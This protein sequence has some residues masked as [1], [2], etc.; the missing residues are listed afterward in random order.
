[1][2]DS[3]CIL[4]VGAILKNATCLIFGVSELSVAM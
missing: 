3:G 2:L 1:M 4:K